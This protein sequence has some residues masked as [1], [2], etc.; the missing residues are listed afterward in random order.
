MQ[1]PREAAEAQL[2]SYV[3]GG[4]ARGCADFFRG[5]TKQQRNRLAKRAAEEL[6]ETFLP[7]GTADD[8]RRRSVAALASLATASEREIHA[9][10]LLH[11]PDEEHSAEACDVIAE[12]WPAGSA[13][14]DAVVTSIHESPVCWTLTCALEAR[15]IGPPPDGRALVVG[16]IWSVGRHDVPLTELLRE[17]TELHRIVWRLFDVPEAGASLHWHD[18]RRTFRFSDAIVTLA[19]EGVLP[20]DR[21][22]DEILQA[23]GLDAPW[24]SWFASLHGRLAPSPEEQARRGDAYLRLLGCKSEGAWDVAL[25]ALTRLLASGALAPELLLQRTEAT[26]ATQTKKNVKRLLRVLQRAG[27]ASTRG[28]AVAVLAACAGLRHSAADVQS[29]SIGIIEESGSREDGPLLQRLRADLDFLA[30]SN[31]QRLKAW[32]GDTPA[33]ESGEGEMPVDPS[34]ERAALLARARAVPER[35]AKLAGLHAAIASTDSPA[36]YVPLDLDPLSIPR[37]GTL[38][39]PVADLDELIDLS[40][41]AVEWQLGPDDLE[42]VIDG[43]ARLCRLRPE[44]FELRTAPLR[45][46][47]IEL[48]REASSG[49]MV[50]LPVSPFGLNG[51]ARVDLLGVI[52]AWLEGQGERPVDWKE[53]SFP[54]RPAHVDPEQARAVLGDAVRQRWIS[55]ATFRSIR[56]QSLALRVADG[57]VVPLL[58][59]PTHVGCFVDP[60]VLVQR[61][62]S[63]V[64]RND[65]YDAILGLLRL[66]PDHRR[67]ALA[68]AADLPGELGAAIRHALGGDE[69]VGRDAAIWYAAAR[70]RSPV[71]DDPAVEQHHPKGGPDAGTA[72][73][74]HIDVTRFPRMERGAF[75]ALVRGPTVPVVVEPAPTEGLPPDR[76]PGLWHQAAPTAF[77]SVGAWESSF[78]P[79]CRAPVLTFQAHQLT[80]FLESQG[81]Y[82]KGDW[83]PLFD[84]DEPLG[85]SG[86]LVIALGL[87][88]RHPSHNKLAEDA[89]AAGIDDGR[90]EPTPLGSVM[91]AVLGWGK[92]TVSRWCRALGEV[93]RIS[94]LHLH[95][96]RGAVERA[97]G[98]ARPEPRSVAGLV[99][100][101]HEWGVESGERVEVPATREWLSGVGGKGKTASLAKAL[102]AEPST[103]RP[104]HGQAVLARMLLRRIER[105]ERWAALA[106][107]SG[108][109]T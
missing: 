4:D 45:H 101:L 65:R 89:L 24:A 8:R 73:R 19:E 27:K 43:I 32:L 79:L 77:W 80:L 99:E 49:T 107:A 15:G 38:I 60:R 102:A 55:V 51:T 47:C 82:W 9:R 71:E 108:V 28:R 12:R 90:I 2:A 76:M 106:V 10:L 34:V 42:R 50:G 91:S 37:L 48:V 105:A 39:V 21:L 94:P 63:A 100:M 5:Q 96:V 85:P 20:R 23:L 88:A 78:W 84:P 40:L 86:L 92:L 68:R 3:R 33:A 13:A 109:A 25:P 54:W 98:E 72:A 97:L 67:E 103:K 52:I 69:P 7:H 59:T 41:R 70:A 1:D 74:Y 75:H 35:W 36:A 44:S 57:K 6:R 22:V 61:A 30:P 46:R 81:T 104:A 16:F 66:A 83:E 18:D 62:V 58:S 26:L 11:V 56:M 17:R 93:A 29:L 87:G 31:Q 95:V 53:P 14:R 64:G